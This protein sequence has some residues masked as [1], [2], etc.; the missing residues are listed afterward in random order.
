MEAKAPKYQTCVSINTYLHMMTQ[1]KS[2]GTR[3]GPEKRDLISFL[4]DS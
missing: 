3:I 4:R 2:G 1:E